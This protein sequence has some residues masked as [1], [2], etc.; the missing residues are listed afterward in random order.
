MAWATSRFSPSGKRVSS[1]PTGRTGIL[2][3]MTIDP[4]DDAAIRLGMW[5]FC[6][7]SYTAALPDEWVNGAA[8]G[9]TWDAGTPDPS[10][11]HAMHLSGFQP[12]HYQDE[13][14]G[15]DQAIRLTPAGLKSSDPEVTVQFS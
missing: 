14:W 12:D 4:A 5:A 11:G 9:A 6:G 15:F 2:D 1:A 13:T 3:D 7:A 8:P 10:N